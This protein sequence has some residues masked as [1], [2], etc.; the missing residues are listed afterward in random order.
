MAVV[1]HE[2]EVPTAVSAAKMF[3]VFLK[4]SDTILPTI[5]PAFIKN[6]EVLEGNGGPGT[7]KKLNFAEGND[8][9]Y[10]ITRI[11]SMDEENLACS[12]TRFDG[13][14]WMETLEK[15][16]Y[17][18]KVIPTPDGGSI[19]QSIVKYYPKGDA[20]IDEE[21]LKAGHDRIMGVFKV[22]EAYLLA[23]PDAFN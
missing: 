4:E 17:D 14:P 2:V 23:N 12:Y 7:V 21:V 20:K 22:I 10:L 19:C 8:F 5:L 15:V 9:K 3:K 16:C 1:T 11:D 6:V 18:E 13:E